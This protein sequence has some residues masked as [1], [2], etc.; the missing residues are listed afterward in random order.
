MNKRANKVV[1]L[2][3]TAAASHT[4]TVVRAERAHLEIEV[5]GERRR[6]ALA[7]HVPPVVRGQRVLAVEPAGEAEWLV[8]AAWPAPG[9][10]PPEPVSLDP[11]TG[12]LHVRAARIDLTAVASIELSCGGTKIRLGVDGRV[13]IDGEEIVS[14]ALGAHR[15]EGATVDIN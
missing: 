3:P 10:P 6:A 4:A 14:S 5:A 12:T 11:A 2:R 7:T 9:E 13:T 15:I 1:P 8:V